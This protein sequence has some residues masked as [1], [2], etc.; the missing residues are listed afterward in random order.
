MIKPGRIRVD[1]AAMLQREFPKQGNRP[2][3]WMPEN[4]HAAKGFYRT[5]S[6]FKNHATRWE[7]FAVFSDT[8]N[9]AK[10]IQS[11]EAMTAVL[12]SR[13]ITIDKEGWLDINDKFTM[14][15]S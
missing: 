12:Q 2:I 5:S 4:I 7:A 3:L 11:D 10:A 15:I 6:S 13:D 8:K 9:L 14:S 1:L